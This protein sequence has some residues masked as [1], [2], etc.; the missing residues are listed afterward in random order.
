MNGLAF[1]GSAMVADSGPDVRLSL[2]VAW[3]V[4]AGQPGQRQLELRSPDEF[5]GTWGD[6]APV[7]VT[8]TVPGDSSRTRPETTSDEPMWTAPRLLSMGATG[9]NR[10]SSC[11]TAR[12]AFGTWE[13]G[14]R[15]RWN[16]ENR[17]T[18]EPGPPAVGNRRT[19]QA[20]GEQRVQSRESNRQEREWKGAIRRGSLVHPDRGSSGGSHRHLCKS[21]SA[22]FGGH[23][24]SEKNSRIAKKGPRT[25]ARPTR[26]G[27]ERSRQGKSVNVCYYC[28]SA[29]GSITSTGKETRWAFAGNS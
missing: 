3:L 20:A 12:R 7:R 6:T 13:A 9:Q 22:R 5:G 21:E 4:A 28:V 23:E 27:C 14:P 2:S 18:I 11:S 8:L 1:T 29:M 25:S 10:S 24:K 26:V 17:R 19:A 15:A 16:G